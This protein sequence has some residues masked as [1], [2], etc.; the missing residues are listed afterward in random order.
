MILPTKFLEPSTGV[1]RVGAT[2]LE[3]LGDLPARPLDELRR[4]VLD[5]L[6][7]RAEHSF[8]PALSLLFLIG[9]IE[10]DE[11]ADAI[12]RVA[13]GEGHRE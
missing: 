2:L 13:S 9:S 8:S 5:A 11:P 3:K 1:L 7:E 4:D 12:V 6:P 10:Y